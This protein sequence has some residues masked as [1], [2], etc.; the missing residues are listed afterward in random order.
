[1]DISMAAAH[2][3]T[4]NFVKFLES[5][6]ETRIKEQSKCHL[7]M[8]WLARACWLLSQVEYMKWGSACLIFSLAN[9]SRSW[10]KQSKKRICTVGL[11]TV[12]PWPV[13]R[14]CDGWS[15]IHDVQS[16]DPSQRASEWNGPPPKIYSVQGAFRFVFLLKIKPRTGCLTW[17]PFGLWFRF[18]HAVDRPS[19]PSFAF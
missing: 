11:P 15:W 14:F 5:A 19:C 10:S 18:G 3:H 13:K 4:Q 8:R 16:L 12:S 9:F 17:P 7:L 1:M 6:H 2:T